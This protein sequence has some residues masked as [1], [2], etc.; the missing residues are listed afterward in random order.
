M[1]LGYLYGRPAS[2]SI[3]LSQKVLNRTSTILDL[4]PGGD[5]KKTPVILIR[6]QVHVAL[7]QANREW[8]IHVKHSK[9]L[10]EDEI[11]EK[12]EVVEFKNVTQPSCKK[13]ITMFGEDKH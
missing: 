3:P 9:C 5:T 1:F 4:I 13:L 6:I 2:G 7:I 10:K 11:L 12:C 8:T